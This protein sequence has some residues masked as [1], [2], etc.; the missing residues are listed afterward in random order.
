MGKS[1]S[2]IGPWYK[3]LI[4]PEGRTALLGFTDNRW[5]EGDQYDLSLG[6]WD[7]NSD[8]VLQGEKYDTII[9]LRVFYFAHDPQQFIRKCY[10]HLNPGGKIY[11]DSCYGDHWRFP[12]FK[13]GWVK[14]GEQEFAY[15]KDNFLW[16]GVWDD[17]FE[18]SF[19]FLEFK[20]KVQKFGY[21]DMKKSILDEVP[22]I[23]NLTDIDQYFDDVTYN[24]KQLWDDMPQLYILLSGERK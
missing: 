18:D 19:A 15:K 16:A 22:C 4:K 11:F 7:I 14:D 6:N 5:W 3:D 17:G 20:R 2:I 1:N 10:E 13:L 12:N 24:M 21:T 9:C 23:L 8:W